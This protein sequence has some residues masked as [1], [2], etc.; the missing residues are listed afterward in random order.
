MPR[1][2]RLLEIEIEAPEGSPQ[3]WD[4]LLADCSRCV[5]PLKQTLCVSGTACEAALLAMLWRDVRV[6]VIR[7]GRV[8]LPGDL[9]AKHG[10]D[11]PLMC[12]ALK[13]DTERGID[14]DQRNSQCNCANGPGGGLLAVLPAYRKVMRDLVVLT[15]RMLAQDDGLPH[16]L[17]AEHREGYKRIVY[18]SR[19][20]LRMIARNG[21]DTLT[22]RPSLGVASKAW[23][24]LRLRLARR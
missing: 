13:L 22:R 4:G 6:D 17:P 5:G 23:I 14:G 16:G 20:T 2:I 11:L 12:K 19:A 8:Y 15:G 1:L 7:E 18:E 24:G 21:Y 9:A 3:T 10:L